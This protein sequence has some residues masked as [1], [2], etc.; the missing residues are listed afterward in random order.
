MCIGL[1]TYI[2]ALNGIFG[3]KKEEVNECREL[4]S[5]KLLN[6]HNLPISVMIKQRA[7]RR[8]IRNSHSVLVGNLVVKE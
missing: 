6:F 5:E 7:S 8:E 3:L 4:H 2:W 1:R